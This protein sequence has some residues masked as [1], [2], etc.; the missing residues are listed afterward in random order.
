MSTRRYQL[1]VLG[2]FAVFTPIFVMTHRHGCW[3]RHAY[4]P[5]CSY[6]QEETMRY[7]DGDRGGYM[8]GCR[9]QCGPRAYARGCHAH[10]WRRSGGGMTCGPRDGRGCGPQDG[11]GGNPR[12]ERASAY[13]ERSCGQYAGRA[14]G[15]RDRRGYGPR[16]GRGRPDANGDYTC[17]YA[18]R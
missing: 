13:D 12:C 10:G 6:A 9:T 11:R 7:D 14:C 18:E 3:G 16:D 17:P 2:A 1:A 5:A 4:V 8:R 15:P